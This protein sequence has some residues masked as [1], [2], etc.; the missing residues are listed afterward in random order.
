MDGFAERLFY[1][2]FTRAT[3][4]LYLSTVI[5]KSVPGL[6]KVRKLA[7]LKPPVV[8][9]GSRATVVPPKPKPDKNLGDDDLLDIL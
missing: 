4:W 9:L 6:D 8:T 3:K 7:G 5:G 1:V 2:G